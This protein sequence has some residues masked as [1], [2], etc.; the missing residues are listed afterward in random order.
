[1]FV[2]NAEG[3]LQPVRVKTGIS[4]GATTAILEG[5]LAE[6]AQVVT[7]TAS[8]ATSASATNTSPLLPFGGR[9]RQG[10][11]SRQGGAR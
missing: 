4:D 6:N 1:V 3:E 2:L 10:G 5:D 9:G 8:P 11:T 7:G